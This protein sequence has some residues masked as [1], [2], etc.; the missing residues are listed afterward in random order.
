MKIG[1]GLE[2]SPK[3]D[4]KG[5]NTSFSTW[6]REKNIKTDWWGKGVCRIELPW[7]QQVSVN[8]IVNSIFLTFKGYLEASMSD[9][10]VLR[11]SSVWN[12]WI[13]E[14]RYNVLEHHQ[15]HLKFYIKS[16]VAI[17][18]TQEGFNNIN[19]VFCMIT[20]LSYVMTIVYD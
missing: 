12:N 18:V 6:K 7:C 10:C 15:F 4:C 1:H 17:L 3:K 9:S 2:I 20:K 8:F 13:I 11:Q 5:A 16:I 19:I 14:S